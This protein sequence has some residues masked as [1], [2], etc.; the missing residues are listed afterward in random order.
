MLALIPVL[1]V[2]DTFVERDGGSGGLAI[3]LGDVLGADDERTWCV[4]R[5]I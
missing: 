1:E 3:W 2:V 5:R 4:W